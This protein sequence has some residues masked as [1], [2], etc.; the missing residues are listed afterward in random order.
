MGTYL[1]KLLNS[2]SP[3]KKQSYKNA[4]FILGFFLALSCGEVN[5]KTLPASTGKT[6]EIIVVLEDRFIGSIVE[7]SLRNCLECEH[8]ALPQPE[9][10]FRISIVP[11][12]AFTGLLKNHKN[13]LIVKYNK[14]DPALIEK[15][16]YLG[17]PSDCMPHLRKLRKNAC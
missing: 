4:I 3:L 7:E 13:L 16:R 1:A 12:S 11:K 9:A 5:E 15:K 10:L 14:K 17:V 6:G 2:S 8:P